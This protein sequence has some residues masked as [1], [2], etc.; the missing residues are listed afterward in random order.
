MEV[1]TV[2]SPGEPQ[3]GK[4]KGNAFTG[5]MLKTRRTSISV[6]LAAFRTDG[7]IILQD[8]DGS[9]GD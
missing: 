6:F 3:H 2:S 9:L 1:L 8:A 7:R 4:S 5:A